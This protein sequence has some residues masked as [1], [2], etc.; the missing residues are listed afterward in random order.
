MLKRR[1]SRDC[2]H[3]FKKLFEVATELNERPPKTL[4]RNTPANLLSEL[5]SK[6]EIAP[7]ASTA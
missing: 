2:S 6:Y 3:S 5:V 7:V 4:K 1:P